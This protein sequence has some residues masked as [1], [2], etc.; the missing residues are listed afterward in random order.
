MWQSPDERGTETRWNSTL[1]KRDADTHGWEEANDVRQENM[2]YEM[3]FRSKPIP[4]T[5]LLRWEDRYPAPDSAAF[6]ATR[7]TFSFK[8]PFD[9]NK[10]NTMKLLASNYNYLYFQNQ[11]SFQVISI[12][13][14]TTAS[15]MV[16]KQGGVQPTFIVPNGL[17]TSPNAFTTEFA[18][19]NAYVSQ[20]DMPSN[21]VN[22]RGRELYTLTFILADETLNVLT[23][24]GVLPGSTYYANFLLQFE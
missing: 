2:S 8:L 11:G 19:T 10:F 1:M 6:P 17:A 24:K 14:L 9:V 15:P 21:T 5:V 13:E 23:Q 7:T 18:R 16:S 22:C 3:T 12:P 20:D 4:R